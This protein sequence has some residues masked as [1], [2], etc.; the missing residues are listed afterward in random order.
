MIFIAIPVI[1]EKA[2]DIG[3]TAPYKNIKTLIKVIGK[4]NEKRFNEGAERVIT[5]IEH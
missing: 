5:P 3:P 2:F 4:P 1:S